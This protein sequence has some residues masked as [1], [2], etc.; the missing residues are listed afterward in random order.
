MRIINYR[1][2][3][4]DNLCLNIY[5]I[6]IIGFY[7]ESID[8]RI[9]NI[10][11]FAKVHDK[12]YVLKFNNITKEIFID[13]LTIKKYNE[14]ISDNISIIVT[15]YDFNIYK[16]KKFTS[17]LL[18]IDENDD[19]ALSSLLLEAEVFNEKLSKSDFLEHF[20]EYKEISD[21]KIKESL[22]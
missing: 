19:I 2:I 6:K 14:L 13:K 21:E 15:N 10:I 20:F 17:N 18:F 11:L 7:I 8:D 9:S 12:K 1:N 16:N 4:D 22:P 5:K 3:I